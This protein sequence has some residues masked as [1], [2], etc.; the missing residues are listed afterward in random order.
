VKIITSISVRKPVACLW[1]MTPLPG[2]TA[3]KSIKFENRAGQDL[4]LWVVNCGGELLKLSFSTKFFLTKKG[5]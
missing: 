3:E 4:S 1:R 2:E 5:G